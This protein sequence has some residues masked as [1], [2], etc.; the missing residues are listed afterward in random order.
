MSRELEQ[1]QPKLELVPEPGQLQLLPPN[2]VVLY[3]LQAL[4]CLLSPERPDR[5]W[6]ESLANL[7]W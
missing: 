6:M 1:Q 3:L 7:W 4:D 5:H 2:L